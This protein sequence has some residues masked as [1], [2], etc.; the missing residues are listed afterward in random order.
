MSVDVKVYVAA[1]PTFKLASIFHEQVDFLLRGEEIWWKTLDVTSAD[2]ALSHLSQKQIP[3][4]DRKVFDY[5]SRPLNSQARSLQLSPVNP[6]LC[7]CAV[8]HL[9]S[10]NTLHGGSS[11]AIFCKKTSTSCKT[12]FTTF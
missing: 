10:S 7:G 3:I 1:L 8:P 5:R 2:V 6:K 9:K 11:I 12:A 4:S